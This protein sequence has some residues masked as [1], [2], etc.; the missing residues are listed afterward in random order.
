MSER[1]TRCNRPVI[2]AVRP[3]DAVDEDGGSM[4]SIALSFE[5]YEIEVVRTGGETWWTIEHDERGR[6][7]KRLQAVEHRRLPDMDGKTVA[8][9]KLGEQLVVGRR[10]H[11]Q[12]CAPAK[13]EAAIEAAR[14]EPRERILRTPMETG[15]CRSCPAE[16]YWIKTIKDRPTPVD[17]QPRRGFLLSKDEARTAKDKPTFVRGYEADGASRAIEEI[18]EGQQITLLDRDRVIVTVYVSHFATCPGR[19]RHRKKDK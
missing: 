5:A 1:C 9:F 13:R 17:K 2:L 7:A 12:S 15:Q 18:T 3:Q 19:E 14:T 10:E 4:P 16:V 6:V 11:A 8:P